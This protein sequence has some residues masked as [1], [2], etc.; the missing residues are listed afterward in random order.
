MNNNYAKACNEVGEILKYIPQEYLNKIPLYVIEK[1]EENKEQNYNFHYNV[2]KEYEEQELL[3]ETKAI[4]ANLYI[5]Y[6]ATEEEKEEIKK[7]HNNDRAKIEFLKRQKYNPDDMFKNKKLQNQQRVEVTQLIELP[8]ENFIKKI[9]N[10][11]K[12]FFGL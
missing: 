2:N 9:I 12:S 3:E 5:D 7:I 10:K 6:W 4:L 8:K 1:L 11:I